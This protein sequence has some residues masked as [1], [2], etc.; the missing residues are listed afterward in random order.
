MLSYTLNNKYIASLSYNHSD[1]FI[2]RSAVVDPMTK[3]L[4]LSSANYDYRDRWE[5]QV[6]APFS[7]TS[8]WEV[9]TTATLSYSAYP[10]AQLEGPLKLQKVAVD[11]FAGQTYRLPTGITAELQTRYTSP[12][13]NGIYMNR[14][15]FT[16]DGGVKKSFLKNKLDARFA[17]A[18]LFQTGWFWGYSVSNTLNYQYKNTPDS[19]RFSL[20]LIYHIGGKLNTGKSH[21]TEEQNRL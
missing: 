11:L 19:R 4:T 12:D 15:Y 5:A 18:D 1:N 6:I 13:L 14:Y 3:I 2:A 8:W 21:R 7:L 20:T 9:N 10:V 16:M 17:F